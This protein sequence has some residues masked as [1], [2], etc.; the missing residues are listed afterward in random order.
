[1]SQNNTILIK[2]RTSGDAGAP[3]SLSGGEL[4]MNE[5]DGTLYY[6][7]Q[8]GVI[9]IGGKGA[10]VDVSS[11][12]SISGV[13]TFVDGITLPQSPVSATDAANKSYVDAL[14]SDLQGKIDSIEG[15]FLDKQVGGT[16]DANLAVTGNLEVGSGS[17]TLY[18]GTSTIGVNTESPTESLDV[19]GNGKFTGTIE[20][21][22]PVNSTHAATKNYVDTATLD[23]GTF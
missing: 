12:Q 15:N 11:S 1:M 18:V 3:V 6:G 20:V 19:V 9:A 7:S 10:Y 16:I 22:D 13:K 23:G 2:R 4:A 8:N 21:S 14:S 5:V 17:T